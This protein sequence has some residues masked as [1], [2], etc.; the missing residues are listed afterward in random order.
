MSDATYYLLIGIAV[1]LLLTAFVLLARPIRNWR[2][3]REMRSALAAFK[4]QREG[5]EAKFH[6]LASRS[7]K[8]RGLRWIDCDF[9]DTVTFA[10]HKA[11]RLLTAFVGVN[12][13]FEAIAGDDMEGVAAVN[14]VRDASAVFHFRRGVW[15]TGGRAVFNMN[16]HE[17]LERQQDQFERVE[18]PSAHAARDQG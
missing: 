18:L 16:P 13:R 12:I 1:G 6:D 15:G 8:P 9:L 4:R 7:G 11:T 10:R 2:Q 3:R 5:L 17:A 14:T